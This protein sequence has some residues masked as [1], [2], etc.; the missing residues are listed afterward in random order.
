MSPAVDNLTD[1]PVFVGLTG[2]RTL[3]VFLA[4]ASEAD[5]A[6]CLRVSEADL[7]DLVG[8]HVT[9]VRNH[10]NRLMGNDILHIWEE[11]HRCEGIPRT[12]LLT[13]LA[14]AADVREA[15]CRTDERARQA[16][17]RQA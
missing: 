16:E 9:T 8:L 7:A 13:P 17:A 12:F 4:M 11:R 10:V 3:D 15:Q 14:S 6:G 2:R 5:E 1:H